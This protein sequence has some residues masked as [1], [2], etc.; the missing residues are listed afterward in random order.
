MNRQPVEMIA[1]GGRNVREIC[2]LGNFTDG[3]LNSENL[4]HSIC[5][6]S[7][8]CKIDSSQWYYLYAR[9]YECMT[10]KLS[11]LRKLQSRKMHAKLKTTIKI[12]RIRSFDNGSVD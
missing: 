10:S 3:Y 1:N 7:R 4:K 6:V 2:S 8:V 9:H 12:E 5:G 11:S